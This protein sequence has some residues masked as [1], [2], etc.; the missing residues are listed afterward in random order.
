M[1]IVNYQ[2]N[3]NSKDVY[4]FGTCRVAYFSH[5]TINFFRKIRNYHSNYYRTDSG[6][7]IFTQPVNYTTKLQDIV[8]NILYMK[9]DLY[10]D[11]NPKDDP[12]FQSIFFRGHIY[13][14]DT[15]MPKTHPL[16]N[17]CELKFHK[18]I[19]EIFY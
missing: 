12:V 3:L 1:D 7:N 9:G 15:I 13:P 17:N 10:S 6:I 14:Q 16:Q 4:I 2:N 18:V 19:I 5:P 8:D 11:K